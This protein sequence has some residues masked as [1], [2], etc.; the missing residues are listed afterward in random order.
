MRKIK[1]VLSLFDGISCGQLALR[2]AGIEVENY[3]ASEIDKKAIEVTKRNF[4]NTIHLGDV[5][6]IKAE[7]LPKID[8][9]I[10]GSP[11]QGISLAGLV[12]GLSDERSSL[13]Y[14]FVG[15]I[16]ECKPKY[17]FLENV[18][19]GSQTTLVMSQALG[20]Y[21]TF[22]DSKLVS[23]QIRKRLYWS[24]FELATP[25]PK[26]NHILDILEDKMIEE[27]EH[28]RLYPAAIRG[29]KIDGKNQQVLEV[30]GIDVNKTNCITSVCKDSVMT[31]L[32][33]GR[34][35]NGL[36]QPYRKFT[37]K[38]YCRLQTLPDDYFDPLTSINQVRKMC[39]NAWTVDVIAHFFKNIK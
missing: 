17:W 10:G 1:N 35:L 2:R 39:G 13:F 3:Y 38:E 21:P 29:R 25:N 37:K 32:K 30:R 7:D 33:P 27:V 8:L 22:V 16:E 11:C 20:S 36:R 12:K 4:P 31:N 24:N 28:S 6:E 23:P 14:R 26:K 9:I 15:L 5:T 18:V 34:Y 19:G